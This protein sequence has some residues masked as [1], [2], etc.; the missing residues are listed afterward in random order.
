MLMPMTM[1]L[2][3]MEWRNCTKMP[4][5]YGVIRQRAR[6]AIG[7]RCSK[8]SITRDTLWRA[9]IDLG[10]TFSCTRKI[11]W[12][13][14]RSGW[15]MWCRSTSPGHRFPWYRSGAWATM[16]T[17]LCC[18]RV[19][20]GAMMTIMMRWWDFCRGTGSMSSRW[21]SIGRISESSKQSRSPVPPQQLA[22]QINKFLLHFNRRWKLFR[23]SKERNEKEKKTKHQQ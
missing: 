20:H 7:T 23:S 10:V 6:N 18:M 3:M 4:I 5:T 9:A 14:I 16:C 1:I 19:S 15:C 22:Q 11:P 12:S 2:M 8:H 21:S 17:R 13:T